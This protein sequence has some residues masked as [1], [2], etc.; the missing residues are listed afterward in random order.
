MYSIIVNCG[1]CDSGRTL[2]IVDPEYPEQAL[3]YN[4]GISTDLTDFICSR[5]AILKN[6]VNYIGLQGPMEYCLNYK[7]DIENKLALEYANNNIEIEVI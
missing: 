3:N 1:P 4:I 2:V 7:E 5:I 6:K